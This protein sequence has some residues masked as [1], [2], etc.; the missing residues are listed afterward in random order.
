MMFLNNSENIIR[1]IEFEMLNLSNIDPF[2]LSHPNSFTL[3][4]S[5]SGNLSSENTG[6]IEKKNRLNIPLG[7][8][9]PKECTL[10]IKKSFH[11][12]IIPCFFFHFSSE[13][14]FNLLSKFY[15]S[16]W[17]SISITMLRNKKNLFL[18]DN[19][20]IN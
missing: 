19:H 5:V 9:C 17:E 14:M 7:S 4:E 2:S 10:T 6:N 16:S 12:D 18:L 13:S 11:L 15:S 1:T 3:L 8:I 20:S